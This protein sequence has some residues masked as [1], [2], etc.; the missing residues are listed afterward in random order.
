M[1]IGVQNKFDRNGRPRTDGRVAI[2]PAIELS[3]QKAVLQ[4][5]RAAETEL[6]ADLVEVHLRGG[7]CLNP[8]G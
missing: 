3:Q 4:L 5:V 6:R 8:S 2:Q 1:R 7:A